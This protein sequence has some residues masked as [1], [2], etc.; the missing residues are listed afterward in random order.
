M[1]PSDRPRDILGK[2]LDSAA[3]GYAL[4]ISDENRER[5]APVEA[6]EGIFREILA[7]H[8]GISDGGLVGV[9]LGVPDSDKLRELLKDLFWTLEVDSG[10][11]AR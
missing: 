8:V 10:G 4:L 6:L 3:T 2:L 9:L 1:E 7:G 5:D 11:D